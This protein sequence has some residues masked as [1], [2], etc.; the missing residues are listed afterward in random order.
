[1]IEALT[2]SSCNMDQTT[3]TDPDS[4]EIICSNCDIVILERIEDNI[5]SERRAYLMEEIDSR[6]RTGAPTSLSST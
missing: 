1:M 6:S 5:H 3:I 4:G 2:C